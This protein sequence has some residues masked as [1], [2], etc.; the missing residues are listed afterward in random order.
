VYS[1]NGIIAGGYG[2]KVYSSGAY[3]TIQ[4]GYYNSVGAQYSF[5]AGNYAISNYERSA[6]FAFDGTSG[7]YSQMENSVNF[8]TV[9]KGL[10]HNGIRLS[11]VDSTNYIEEDNYNVL[12]GGQYNSVGGSYNVILGGRSNYVDA[13]YASITGGFKNRVWANYGSILGGYMNQ[14]SGRFGTVLGGGRNYARGRY[15]V[16]AGFNA[17]AFADYS[18]VFGYTGEECTNEDPNTF[19]M[20]AESWHLN[21]VD[22]GKSLE[23]FS[24][25]SLS[26]DDEAMIEVENKLEQQNK[27]LTE[28]RKYNDAQDRTSIEQQKLIAE[29][30]GMIKAVQEVR[31]SV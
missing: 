18:V 31:S 23:Y 14:V 29:L 21:G 4:G 16:A 10:Y 19:A 6:S 13:T 2:N 20:C 30:Q 28:H 1:Y 3:G 5:S 17:N 12:K 11:A 24:R 27:L 8:C 15:S 7:C 26:A 22:V 9:K 25:R